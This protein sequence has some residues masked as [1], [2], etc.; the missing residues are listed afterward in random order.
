MECDASTGAAP[1]GPILLNGN[2]TLTGAPTLAAL[3]LE[4]DMTDNTVVAEHNGFIVEQARFVATPLA[5][6]DV[7]ELI[8]FVGGG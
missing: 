7:V 2:A 5:P 4:L 8:S 1:R 3:L 6:G